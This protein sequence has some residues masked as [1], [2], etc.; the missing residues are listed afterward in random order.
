MTSTSSKSHSHNPGTART[1]FFNFISKL[2]LSIVNGLSPS[3]VSKL[4]K[5][6][7]DL[8]I[9]SVTFCPVISNGTEFLKRL[10]K[11]TASSSCL[12][13]YKGIKLALSTLIIFLTL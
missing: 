6:P 13:V 4:T 1:L 5:V 2:L 8:L 3:K 7:L 12:K 11:S 9:P 10:S